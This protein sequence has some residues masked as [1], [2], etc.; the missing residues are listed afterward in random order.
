MTAKHVF[1]AVEALYRD[2]I[3]PPAQPNGKVVAYLYRVDFQDRGSPHIHCL[4]WIEG[5]PVFKEDG[6]QAV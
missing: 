6:E 2:F 4:L 3:M 1:E 5:A